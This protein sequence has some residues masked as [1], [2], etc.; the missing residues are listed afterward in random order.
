MKVI[1]TTDGLQAFCDQ[2]RSAPF[3]AIDTEFMRERTYWPILC[4]IQAAADGAEAVIDPLAEAINL[5]PLFEVLADEGIVKVFHAA[6]QDVEIFVNLTGRPPTPIFDSQI[7]AMACGFG[8]QI[9]YEPLMRSLV[10]AKIDKGSRFTDWARR[11]LSENQLAY[12]LSDVTY[13]R[14]AYPILQRKLSRDGREAWVAEEMAMLA[15]VKLYQ[16]EPADAWRR[17]KLRGIR[18]SELGPLIKLA[19]WRE[20]EAQA[21]DLP[22]GRVAKDEALLELAR[23]RPGNADELGRARSIPKGAERSKFGEGMLA[24]IKEGLQIAKEDLP[25]IEKNMH[26]EPPPPDVVDMLKV[27][28]KRQCERHEVAPRLIASSTDLESLALDPDAD[29]PAMKGWRREV[30]G[31]AATRLMNGQIALRLANGKLDLVEL[32]Q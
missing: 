9:G 12:A 5:A 10:G 24:A 25:V 31:A 23:M 3:V 27:V 2:I 20:R 14:A 7:A 19:E 32:D 11:P 16:T 28:L 30:F 1:T 17:L 21:R 6:R 22:R 29:I 4:L 13:L 8:D 18:S 15:D 26:R